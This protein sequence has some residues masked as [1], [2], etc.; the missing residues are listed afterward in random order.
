MAQRACYLLGT[1]KCP[2]PYRILAISFKRDAARN[3]SER[4]KKRC[5]EQANR[6][7]SFT[8]D[9]FAKTMVDRFRLG[10]P[11]DWKPVS[12]YTVMTSGLAPDDIR[13]W[14]IDA[15]I[16][17]HSVHSKNNNEIKMI[18]DSI[19][20]GYQLP[21]VGTEI[22]EKRK[23]LG[24]RWWQDRLALPKDV[25]SLSFPMLSRLAAH[26]LREN[27]T[28]LK[29]LRTTYRFVF[30]DEF[31]DTTASQYDLIQSAF[32]G[33]NSVLT[34][35][36]DNKQRIMLWAGAMPNVFDVFA[37]DFNA[38]HGDLLRNYRSAPELVEMQHVIAQ[39]LES[40]VQP[41]IS[42]KKGITGSC[43]ILEFENYEA[44]ANYVATLIEEGMRNE[45]E[46]PRDF[47]ILV[48]QRTSDMISTLQGVLAHRGIK[49]RDESALQDTLSEPVVCLILAILRLATRERDP[50]AWTFLTSEIAALYGWREDEDASRISKE[51]KKLIKSV[52]ETDS[53]FSAIPSEIISL[54]G[55]S[56][57]RSLYR[58]YERGPFLD[59]VIKNFSDALED[60]TGPTNAETV[61]NVIGEDFVPAMTIHKSKGLEFNTVI[62]L[63]LEDSQWWN[64]SKQS[65]EEIRSFFVAFSRAIENVYFT[66]SNTRLTRY[67][68][69]RQDRTGIRDLYSILQDAGVPTISCDT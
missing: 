64:F 57:F 49:L 37:A 27:P 61:N 18:F 42:A 50:E 44:E 20:H 11:E 3:I 16:P 40:G 69:R 58:Q 32:F 53:E 2:K 12:D 10:L 46:S 14:L 19:M 56:L 63:G 36:G 21:Y 26:L 41:A 6:F 7:D 68:V 9:A 4:V 34:A 23:Q 5:G 13:H 59:T 35:V 54:L 24:L 55:E 33:S 30:L 25:P 45:G 52:R 38:D 51:A 67:G 48:R 65:E 22:P 17:D 66:F 28:I 31:Q 29:T 8:L 1:G 60:Y 43:S 47:C 62:F 39:A 15:G